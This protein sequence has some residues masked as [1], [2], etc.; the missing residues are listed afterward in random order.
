M[1][2]NKCKQYAEL[3]KVGENVPEWNGN[4]KVKTESEVQTTTDDFNNLGP[5]DLATRYSLQIK[6]A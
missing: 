1:Y 2:N 3:K 5:I 6:N 4:L